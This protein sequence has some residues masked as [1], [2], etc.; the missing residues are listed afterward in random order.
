MEVTHPHAATPSIPHNN[1]NQLAHT[2]PQTLALPTTTQIHPHSTKNTHYNPT[3]SSSNNKHSTKYSQHSEHSHTHHKNDPPS[4]TRPPN[5]HP[6]WTTQHLPLTPLP[7]GKQPRLPTHIP[8][9]HLQLH[10]LPATSPKFQH[11][12]QVPQ[13]P[14]AETQLPTPHSPQ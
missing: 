9:S 3:A 12:R 14:T 7:H 5:V 4:A 2:A 6:L 1:H 8:S 11:C 10:T 13:T